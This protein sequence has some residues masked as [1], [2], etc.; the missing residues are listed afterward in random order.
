MAANVEAEIRGGVCIVRCAGDDGDELVRSLDDELT[1]CRSAGAHDV[2]VDLQPAAG[3]D[4]GAVAVLSRAAHAFHDAGGEFVVICEDRD[5]RE[6]LA[7][8]GLSGAPS[9]ASAGPALEAPC[10]AA[11]PTAL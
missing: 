9:G 6:R 10:G 7:A 11:G 8:A 4:A 3:I 1:R 2:V 5:L